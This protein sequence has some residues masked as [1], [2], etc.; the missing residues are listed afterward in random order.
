MWFGPGSRCLEIKMMVNNIPKL[1][2]QDNF[3]MT[4]QI[5]SYMIFFRWRFLK[6][7]FWKTCCFWNQWFPQCS[8]V[9]VYWYALV[10]F[11][12]SRNSNCLLRV[13]S[14]QGT[15]KNSPNCQTPQQKSYKLMKIATRYILVSNGI[16]NQVKGTQQYCV[17]YVWIT[18]QEWIICY[19]MQ[20]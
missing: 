19:G 10:G 2:K 8:S 20:L 4:M 13:C 15:D 7:Y 18:L 5:A 17:V 14:N 11:V 16:S 12:F 1:I 9:V 6:R 3:L